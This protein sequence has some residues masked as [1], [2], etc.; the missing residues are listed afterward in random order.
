MATE[1]S[2]R[3]KRQLK[4]DGKYHLP[5]D[6]IYPSVTGILSVIAKPALVH[7]AAR[8]AASL[9][10]SDPDEYDTAEKA[11]AGVRGATKRAADRGSTVHSLAE[12]LDRGGQVAL[13]TLPDA[14]KPHADAYL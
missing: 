8:T 1:A 6:R 12:S 7:W 4:R 9:V 3:V 11:A 13:E 2:E 14:L 5:G 10:L